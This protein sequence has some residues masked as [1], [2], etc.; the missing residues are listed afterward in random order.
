MERYFV[1]AHVPPSELKRARA[2]GAPPETQLNE[3]Y[4][5]DPDIVQVRASLP[6][7]TQREEAVQVA[8][9]LCQIYGWIFVGVEIEREVE[10]AL[11]T[12][13]KMNKAA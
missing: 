11:P 6:F 1:L 7:A 8:E 12:V 3:H 13:T 10:H 2:Y 4:A 5:H 9:D